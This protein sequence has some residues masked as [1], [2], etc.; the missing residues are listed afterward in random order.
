MH[1]INKSRERRTQLQKPCNVRT[2]KDH[3]NMQWGGMLRKVSNKLG[4]AMVPMQ[5]KEH[6]QNK[7]GPRRDKESKKSRYEEFE[8]P[9]RNKETQYKEFDTAEIQTKGRPKRSKGSL[10]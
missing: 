1:K 6:S 8:V 5:S 2:V 4:K 9:R 10:Q 3:N 7:E